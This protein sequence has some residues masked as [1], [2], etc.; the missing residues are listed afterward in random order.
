MN[1]YIKLFVLV[2]L[3]GIL[4]SAC[5]KWE[6]PEFKAPVYTG[7]KANMTIADIKAR[8]TLL[9]QNVVD[10][11]CE[12][13]G[14]Q[15]IVK[16]VVVSSDEGGNCYK[17]ITVED[18]TGGIEIAVNQ[19][20]LFNEYPVGQIVYINCDG[21]VVGD[22]SN[23]YQIGWI[24]ENSIGRINY[25]MLGKYLSKDGLPSMD[26]IKALSP[27]GGICELTSGDDIHIDLSNC[28]VTLKKATFSS[29]C[30]G[31]QL[32]S[33][34]LTCDRELSNFYVGTKPVVVRTS[35]YAYFRNRVIDAT[36]EYDLTG[37]LTIYKNEYQLT[38]RTSL[39]MVESAAEPQQQEVLV[40]KVDFA[41]NTSSEITGWYNP[42][43][44]WTPVTSQAYGK[45]VTHDGYT[46]SSASTTCDDWL[47]SPVINLDG[48]T[49]CYLRVNH[50]LQDL[51][52]PNFYQV[53]YSTTY[54]GGEINPEDWTPYGSLGNYPTSFGMTG[55]LSPIPEGDF[56]IAIRYNKN[57]ANIESHRWSIK[58][59]NF[60]K[61]EWILN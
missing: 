48:E 31:K 8:H 44:N 1:K 2:V 61:I 15:F 12:F 3:V 13:P 53:Y 20:G 45:I 54:T 14:Q 58:E 50:Q 4:F 30:H 60:Y 56:R 38:L 19:S 32:A 34:E 27:C 17:Y 57:N 10:S 21:L 35:N 23:K 36:K 9:G 59:L 40:K 26:N 5:K 37:I 29:D 41:N 43:G 11:I 33:N 52:D 25:M 51:T 46:G 42:S 18:E 55:Q 28:L 22:Y 39:D 6:A 49:D 24:Y 7:K 47:V 16:A